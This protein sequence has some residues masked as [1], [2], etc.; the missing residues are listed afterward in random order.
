MKSN[1]ENLRLALGA[2]QG[3]LLRTVLTALII[4]IGI[5]AL[6]GILTAIEAIESSISS[7]FSS[8]GSNSFTI[9]NSGL[10][11]RIGKDGVKPK[12]FERITYE[13]AISFQRMFSYPSTISI[14]TFATQ[15]GVV[16][17]KDQKS[18]PN[19][20]VVGSDHNYLDVSGY[21]LKEGR[22]FSENEIASASGVVILGSEMIKTIFPDTEKH[23]D[24]L[25]SIGNNKYRVIGVLDEKGSSMGFA[26]DRICIIPVS[27]VKIRFGDQKRSYT[28]TVK[29]SDILAMETASSE[30]TGLF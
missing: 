12:R 17:F 22:N 27:N 16:K 19:I 9:R 23:L 8:M 5:M 7:N 24:Q 2:I 4:A 3:Q 18:N 14:S 28:L 20:L 29:V 15:L 6:V 1:L 25:I 10:G 13:E 26:N 11:I 21:K 30:S